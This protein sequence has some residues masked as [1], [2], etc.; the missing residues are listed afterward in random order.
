MAGSPRHSPRPRPAP[1][2][3]QACL[4][5]AQDDHMTAALMQ[6][7]GPRP[8]GG[9][10]WQQLT[11]NGARSVYC[12]GR[13]WPTACLVEPAGCAYGSSLTGTRVGR[14]ATSSSV[15]CRDGV[16][17]ETG[18]LPCGCPC[19]GQRCD[20]GSPLAK[21]RAVL[22]FDLPRPIAILMPGSD[23]GGTSDGGARKKTYCFSSP[24]CRCY[25]RGRTTQ[26]EAQ[27]AQMRRRA[28]TDVC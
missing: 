27:E 26:H 12:G 19:S 20:A 16:V 10:G 8:R 28:V 5:R 22:Q 25:H 13:R 21:E 11:N 17:R 9:I 14:T 4:M 6:A 7:I 23:S 2:G 3:L 1:Q 24:G 18:S 15:E